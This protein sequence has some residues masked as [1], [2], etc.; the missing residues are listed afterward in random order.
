[1]VT[2]VPLGPEALTASLWTLEGS[3]IIVYPH[4]NT[5]ILFLTKGLT[6]ARN[7]TREGLSP[8]MEMHMCVES[9]LSREGSPAVV[10][11]A[12]VYGSIFFALL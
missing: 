7:F 10:M 3:Y 4:M 8:V 12:N 11:G 5:Q 1:M 9:R 2:H 6:T